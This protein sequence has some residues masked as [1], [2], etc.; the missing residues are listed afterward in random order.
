MFPGGYEPNPLT[1]LLAQQRAAGS[2]LIDLTGEQ[3]RG[4]WTEPGSPVS[5]APARLGAAA[6]PAR[7]TR[8]PGSS[9]GGCPLLPGAGHPHPGGTS[10]AYRQHQR[11]LR[12]VAEAA[13]RTGDCVLVPTP[14]YPLCADLA[15]LERVRCGSYRLRPGAGGW[16]LDGPVWPPACAGARER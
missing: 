9:R 4:P 16:C 14:G 2:R 12:L 11:G 5:G 3:S 7:T 13:L 8:R 6:L 1:R 15:R 10:R